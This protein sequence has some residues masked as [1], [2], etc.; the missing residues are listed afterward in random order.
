MF[1]K[2]IKEKAIVKKV[3][4]NSVYL[5]GVVTIG[6]FIYCGYSFDLTLFKHHALTKKEISVSNY[7][8]NRKPSRLFFSKKP[9]RVITY[10]QNN[11]EILDAFGEIDCIV[12]AVGRF[13]YFKNGDERRVN[14]IKDLVPYY[15]QNGID[16]ET[17]RFLKPDFIMGWPSSFGKR[18]IWSL[19]DTGYWLQRNVNCYMS[20]QQQNGKL[21]ETIDGE[22]K[23]IL[24]MGMI[25]DKQAQ[26]KSITT[27]IQ[28]DVQAYVDTYHTNQSVMI[29]D[30]YGNTISAYGSNRLAGNIVSSLGSRLVDTP[31]RIGKEDIL[32]ANPDVIFLIYKTDEKIKAKHWFMTTKEFQSLKAVKNNKVYMLPLTYVYN[33]GL[34]IGDGIEII[35]KALAN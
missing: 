30:F 9:Q 34:R 16:K 27:K 22:L 13:V 15:G 2:F 19:G 4:K 14:R 3:I 7:D 6:Y 18:G 32:F 10:H 24:D 25:F 28:Q 31:N 5:F 20:L 17:A 1:I 11:I 21:H 33:S 26:A 35:S 23:F 29:L 12:G 8:T